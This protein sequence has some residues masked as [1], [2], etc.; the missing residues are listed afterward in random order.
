MLC[1][2]CNHINLEFSLLRKVFQFNNCWEIDI[3]YYTYTISNPAKYKQ[4]IGI[5]LNC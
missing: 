2:N 1:R 4:E 5:Y 3:H